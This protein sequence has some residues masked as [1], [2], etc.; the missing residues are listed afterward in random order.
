MRVS[1]D[2]ARDF[3]KLPVQCDCLQRSQSPGASPFA[4]KSG[5]SPLRR[6]VVRILGA[7]FEVLISHL[8]AS[9]W[10]QPLRAA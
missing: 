4:S 10:F 7:G 5:M 2:I 8:R 9:A 6:F 3:S 1:G